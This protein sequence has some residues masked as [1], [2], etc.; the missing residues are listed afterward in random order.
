MQLRLRD[1]LN[2]DLDQVL[3]FSF[4][5]M[6]RIAKLLDDSI[7]FADQLLLVLVLGLELLHLC[8]LFFELLL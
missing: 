2:I 8:L 6:L 1:I 3:E 4:Y 5:I 7:G